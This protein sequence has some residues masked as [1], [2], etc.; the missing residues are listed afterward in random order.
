MTSKASA[1]SLK[2]VAWWCFDDADSIG[3]DSINNIADKIQGLPQ[4]MQYAGSHCSTTGQFVG[5]KLTL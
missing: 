2:P 3:L 1:K 4:G 5:H